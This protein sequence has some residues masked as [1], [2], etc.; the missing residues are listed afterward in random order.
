MGKDFVYNMKNL[1]ALH[2]SAMR[3]LKKLRREE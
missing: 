1:E 2:K 3:A